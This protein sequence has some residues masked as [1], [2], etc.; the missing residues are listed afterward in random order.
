M[1]PTTAAQLPLTTSGVLGRPL[2]RLLGTP[3]QLG[4]ENSMRNPRRTAQTAAALMVGLALVSAIAVLGASLSA[5]AKHNVD[6]AVAADY[7][8]TRSGGVSRS[9][10]PIVERV[11]GVDAI[12]TIYFGQFEFRGSLSSLTATTPAHLDRTVHLSMTAGSA[13]PA[14]AAGDLLL[15]STTAASDHLHVGSVAPVVFAQTGPT[16][17]RVGGIY[18]ANALVGSFVVSDATFVSH[19]DNPHV[20]ALLISGPSDLEGTF[21][22]ALTAYPDLNIRTRAQYEHDVQNNVNQLLGL[23][24]VLLALAVLI[25]MIG[26]VNT[27]MLSVFERTREIGL[28]RAVGMRRSQV[29][30]MIRAESVII[31]LFGAV[32]GLVIGTALGVALAESLRRSGV[33]TISIPVASLV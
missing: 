14:L 5:S 28:L 4:R 17:L 23:I 2:A 25:A 26:I 1:I 18:D 30:A 9:V 31:A 32:I 11:P 6:D 16:T 15:D 13:A 8:I 22:T 29:R 24:Y 7:L 3:G 21:N 10:A 19:F 20:D 27:L 12:A 33:S